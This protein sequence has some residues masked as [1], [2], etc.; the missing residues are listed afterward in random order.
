MEDW[1]YLFFMGNMEVT[2]LPGALQITEKTVLHLFLFKG[3]V[4]ITA[5]PWASKTMK[6]NVCIG[7]GQPGDRNL[8]HLKNDVF[9]VL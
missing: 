4:E 3:H 9:I 2:T 1:F 6:N 7:D 5:P 8:G